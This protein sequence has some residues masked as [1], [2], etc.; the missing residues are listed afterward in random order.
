MRI[1]I[2]TNFRHGLDLAQPLADALLPDYTVTCAW[3][4]EVDPATRMDD[5][6]ALSAAWAGI[7]RVDLR[8]VEDAECVVV[9]APHGRLGMG[10][11]WEAGHA[12]AKGI[13]VLIVTFDDQADLF[14][15]SKAAATSPFFYLPGVHRHL[16]SRENL[17]RDVRKRLDTFG[18]YKT[19]WD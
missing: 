10:M 4:Q 2:A 8:A 3:W 7:A 16:T 17:H 18:P 15:P 12:F 1:Y 19:A 9:L 14:D 5:K 11:W 13:P 6:R